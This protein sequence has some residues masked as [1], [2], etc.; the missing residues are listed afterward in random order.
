MINLI[1]EQA[2][3]VEKQQNDFSYFLDYESFKAERDTKKEY[4]KRF[5]KLSEYEAP[6]EF[7]WL[8]EAGATE[9]PN[10]DSIEKRKRGIE[11]LKKDIYISEAVEILKDLSTSIK[12]ERFIAQNKKE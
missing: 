12:V 8:P 11:S 1:D 5:K 7:E 6:Y 2:L 9:L 3:W 4:S 10:E